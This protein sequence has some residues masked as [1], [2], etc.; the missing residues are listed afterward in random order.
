MIIMSVLTGS[1]PL[2]F[3]ERH[4][5]AMDQLA[6]RL[7]RITRAFQEKKVP[8]AL[9]GGQAVNLWIATKDQGGGRQTKD[10]DILLKRDDLPLAKAGGLA[11]GLDYFETLG[12]GMFLEQSDPNPRSGVHI[13][14]AEEKVRPEN[15]LPAPGVQDR[16]EILPGLFVV[17]L[18]SLVTMK[19]VSHRELDRVHL[20]DMIDVGL[21][22]RAMLDGL[23][24]ELAIRLD[25]LL[26]E[27][28]R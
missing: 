1:Q 15:L 12:V 2:N 22:D 7:E 18:V 8:Y 9:I 11:A 3:W 21:I 4:L 26:T 13:V 17:P 23:A 25:A 14:W 10:I 5:F 19:L 24:A 20:R 28:G 6:Q 16:Q 27:G